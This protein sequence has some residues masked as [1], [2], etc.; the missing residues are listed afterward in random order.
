MRFEPDK[1][2]ANPVLV[3]RF[4]LERQSLAAATA[5]AQQLCALVGRFGTLERLMVERYWKIPEWFEAALHLRTRD[6]PAAF[7]A[8][9]DTLA[10][11]CQ[12]S[13]GEADAHWAV[14]DARTDSPLAVPGLDSVRWFAID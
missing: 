7:V 10:P 2:P 9:C 11:A 8:L 1:D 14:W 4:M 13:S 6:R 5:D 3:A 12:R